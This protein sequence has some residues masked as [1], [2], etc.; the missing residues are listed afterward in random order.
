MQFFMFMGVGTMLYTSRSIA[1]RLEFCAIL[2]RQDH[3]AAGLGTYVF[4]QI[5]VLHLQN[6]ISAGFT[7]PMNEGLES[8]PCKVDS[9][10]SELRYQKH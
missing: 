4:F 7:L 2:G 8:D 6:S 5:F 3:L 9:S 1:G 10:A